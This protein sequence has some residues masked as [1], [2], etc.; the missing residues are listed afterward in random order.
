MVQEDRKVEK[1]REPINRRTIE[2]VVDD[3]GY[4]A[5]APISGVYC[6]NLYA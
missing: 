3:T 1:M 5:T 6:T 2:R 4:A